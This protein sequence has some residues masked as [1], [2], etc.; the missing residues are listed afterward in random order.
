MYRDPLTG[1]IAAVTQMS[2][3][4]HNSKIKQMCQSETRCI[5]LLECEKMQ[6]PFKVIW[7]LQNII[8][9]PAPVITILY[10]N[11]FYRGEAAISA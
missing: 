3:H 11:L 10:W 5:L 2:E 1:P 7:V 8:Y 4:Y 9:S 6:L